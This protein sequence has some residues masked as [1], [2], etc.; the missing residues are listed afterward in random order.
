[1][2]SITVVDPKNVVNPRA[3][4]IVI[5]DTVVEAGQGRDRQ[6]ANRLLIF[7]GTIAG[8]L[9]FTTVDDLTRYTATLDL[10]QLPAHPIFDDNPL[11]FIT[12][13]DPL[14]PNRRVLKAAT[15]ATPATIGWDDNADVAIWGVDAADV[16]E[17]NDHLVLHC[18][19]AIQG[20]LSAI[21]R[22][23][24]QVNLLAQSL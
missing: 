18:D 16:R 7:T 13:N 21:G 5:P 24:Y 19:C 11:R 22:I 15:I 3:L 20:E 23:S 10:S 9:P 2:P 8:D 14:D 17:D 1:M 12:I 6:I 4:E